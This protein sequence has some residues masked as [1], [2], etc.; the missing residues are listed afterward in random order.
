MSQPPANSWQVPA[1]LGYQ[2]AAL[3]DRDQ[4][5]LRILSIFW[6]VAAGLA[7]LMGCF[8]ILHVVAGLVMIFARVPTKPGEPPLALFGWLFFLMG[9]A[10][11]ALGWTGAILAFFTARSLTGR[12]RLMLCYVAAAVAC[13]SIPFGLILGVFT[14]VVL[15]RP[16]VKASFH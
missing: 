11:M 16:T 12:R 7:A 13:L 14:F 6:Y 8:P 9:S 10:F 2:S 5:H 4:E 3:I 1:D 15:S